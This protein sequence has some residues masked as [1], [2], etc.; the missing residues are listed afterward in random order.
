MREKWTKMT[1]EVGNAPA[2]ASRI[3]PSLSGCSRIT[4]LPARFGS[5]SV[6]RAVGPVG[7]PGTF[8]AVPAVEVGE[9][10]VGECGGSHS[11]RS[12]KRM[13]LP[14]VRR[15]MQAPLNDTDAAGLGGSISE[16]QSPPRP[17]P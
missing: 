13:R 5:R 6:P 7:A 4:C 2:F 15:P 11:T 14:F 1:A 9:V 10:G 8:A 16:H 12:R 3:S 17:A